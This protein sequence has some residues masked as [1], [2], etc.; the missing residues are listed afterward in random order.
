MATAKMLGRLGWR[1]Q[2]ACCN[3]ARPKRN[4]KREE[5]NLWQREQL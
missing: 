5:K 3:R 2:C 1:G 4:I